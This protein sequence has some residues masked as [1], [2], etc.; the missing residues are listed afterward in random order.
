MGHLILYE[1][2]SEIF[3]CDVT[4]KQNVLY[5]SID[6]NHGKTDK[7]KHGIGVCLHLRVKPK[8]LCNPKPP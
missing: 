4:Q 1:D 7:N 5:L 2:I 3:G 8:R 6:S